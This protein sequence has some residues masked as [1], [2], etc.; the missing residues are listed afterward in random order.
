MTQSIL[1][2]GSMGTLPRST[3]VR[4]AEDRGLTRLVVAG[5]QSA[6]AARLLPSS[7]ALRPGKLTN[8]GDWEKP[9]QWQQTSRS[10]GPGSQESGSQ[11]SR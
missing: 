2:S 3:N 5:D 10:V 1:A 9:A 7:S 8:A 4:V 11:E 6:S